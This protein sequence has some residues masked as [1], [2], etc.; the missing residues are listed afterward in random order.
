MQQTGIMMKRP[1]LATVAVP[2]KIKAVT[3]IVKHNVMIVLI[4]MASIDELQLE[5][6]FTT[7]SH[8]FPFS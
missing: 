6:L 1:Q 7:S 3:M 5:R 8:H 4:A 2:V